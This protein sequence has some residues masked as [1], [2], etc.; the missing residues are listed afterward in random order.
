MR[1]T[2]ALPAL[3]AFLAFPA[4]RRSA[5]GRVV[6]ADSAGVRVT[7]TT[8]DDRRVSA[9]DTVPLLSL[10]GPDAAGPTQFS[11]VQ[12]V[13]LDAAGRL[14]VADG[15]SREVR[16]FGTD[17]SHRKT[18]GGPGAGPG[19]FR[20]LRFLGAFRGDSV[21]LWDARNPRLTVLDA[22]GDVVRTALPPGSD[23]PTPVAHGVFP[24][25]TLLAQVPRVVPAAAL[26]RG[27]LLPDTVRL[28]R[29]D[30]GTGTW[31]PLA[32]VPGPV[33]LWTGRSQVPVPFTANPGYDVRGDTLFLASGPA[34]RV[35]VYQ[36]GRL[37]AEY[38]VARPPRRVEDDDV[39]AYRSFVER[40]VPA[41]PL[42][43]DYLGALDNPA[44]PDVLPAYARILAADDG[45]I[46]ARRFTADPL[47]AATWDVYARNGEWKGAVKMPHGFAAMAISA[48]RVAGVW[49]DSLD[50]EYVRLYRQP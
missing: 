36:A 24:D 18:V 20:A 44:R 47:A 14:W 8:P 31:R 2:I 33:W 5:P 6:V 42:R 39:A 11:N 29:W 35:R 17:G 41:G 45:R 12:G 1:R 30:P 9:L 37:R 22:D 40:Y 7:V 48:N 3:L 15:G 10:G 34:Y 43:T 46:W 28:I 25:G 26:Q 49:R 50:V 23:A 21:A 4:C 19:E 38:G 27:A 13:H 16:I 32:T